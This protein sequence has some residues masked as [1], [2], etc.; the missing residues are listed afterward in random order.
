MPE[1]KNTFLE[2]KMN[3]D[4]DARLLKN[5]EY[6]DAQN[7]YVTKSEGSNVGTAQNILGNKLNYTAGATVGTVIGYFADSERTQDDKYK[8]FYLV[9]GTGSVKDNIYYYEAGSTTAP[10]SLIDNT[11]NFLNF[12]TDYLI[13]GVNLIDDLLFWT[14]DLNQPRRINIVTAKA[15]TTYYDNEDK[16]SVAKYYPYSAPQVLRQVDGT[17]HSGMQLLKTQARLNGAVNNSKTLIIDEERG[18]TGANISHDVHV[19]QEIYDNVTF[20]GK[21]TAVSADGLTI[22]SDTNITKGDDTLLTFLNQ[23][24]ELKEKFVRFAYRFKFKDSEY[25]LIS[26]FTQHCFIPKTYNI[27]YDGHELADVDKIPGLNSAQRI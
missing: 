13:T 8:I 11:D 19:G 5:G 18:S 25:S 10:I 14:D 3:K 15:A 24:D 7:I 16:I 27:S 21:V 23:D 26:P 2:G 9:K 12:N 4:L 20:L 22:T 6:V 17:D 1:L